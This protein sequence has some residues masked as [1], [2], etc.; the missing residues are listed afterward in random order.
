MFMTPALTVSLDYVPRYLHLLPQFHLQ[1]TT[2]H[3]LGPARPIESLEERSVFEKIATMIVQEMTRD[4]SLCV[5]KV[6]Q[7]KSE[8]D[9]KNPM[10]IWNDTRTTI[11]AAYV[12]MTEV[13][14]D[15]HETRDDELEAA[16]R[17]CRG[18]F[19]TKAASGRQVAVVVPRT[20][21]G[22]LVV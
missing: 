6:D 13:L 22:Q 11:P 12:T 21:A 8:G 20:T 7:S 19:Q 2:D 14:A 5:M 15:A 1:D 10:R 16:H 9:C 3:G 17:N 18:P 4:A